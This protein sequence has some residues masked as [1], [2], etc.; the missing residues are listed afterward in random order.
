M[1]F[2]FVGCGNVSQSSSEPT[3]AAGEYTD[4]LTIP[5]T[6]T[7]EEETITLNNVTAKL[8]E[9]PKCNPLKKLSYEGFFCAVR[10]PQSRRSFTLLSYIRIAVG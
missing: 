1:L 3:G 8:D 6:V 4:K 7:T 9:I 10:S 5:T 2:I